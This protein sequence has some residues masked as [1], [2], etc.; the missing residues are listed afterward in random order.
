MDQKTMQFEQ[1]DHKIFE[2]NWVGYV[3]LYLSALILAICLT[4]LPI[5]TYVTTSSPMSLITMLVYLPAFPLYRWLV[6]TYKYFI[7][8][9]TKLNTYAVKDDILEYRYYDKLS[10]ET[11]IDSISL[12][13]IE[14]CHIVFYEARHFFAL[15]TSSGHKKGDEESSVLPALHLSTSNG[16]VPVFLKQMSLMDQWVNVLTVKGISTFIHTDEVVDESLEALD[17]ATMVN[18][19]KLDFAHHENAIKHDI[20]NSREQA[21]LHRRQTGRLPA[22]THFRP[23]LFGVILALNVP[24]ALLSFLAVEQLIPD[25]LG[26]T[27]LLTY[28]AAYILYVYNMQKAT[29]VRSLKFIPLSLVCTFIQIAIFGDGASGDYLAISFFGAQIVFF[30]CIK[31]FFTIGKKVRRQ[32]PSEHQEL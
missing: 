2:F 21:L 28:G 16:V 10:R 32:F 18:G 15:Q 7:W 1:Q 8:F 19:E 23:R 5:Y 25:L 9:N 27:H 31:L 14:E 29:F 20:E 17:K 26:W 24:L 22:I 6:R 4:L 11:K 3:Y 13:Q 12:Q 30:L